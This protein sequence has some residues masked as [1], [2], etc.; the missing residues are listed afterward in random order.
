[1]L[2]DYAKPNF[3]WNNLIDLFESKELLFNELKDMKIISK[4][5]C[6]FLL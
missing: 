4:Y 1:M 3:T 6:F 5:Y 2:I